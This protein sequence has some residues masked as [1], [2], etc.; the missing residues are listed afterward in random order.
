MDDIRI[1]KESVIN[2]IEGITAICEESAASTE[3]ITAIIEEQLK[4]VSTVT[5]ASKDLEEIVSLLN[6]LISE[7]KL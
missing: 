7:F 6:K 2:S 1:Y 5:N 3:E 4:A